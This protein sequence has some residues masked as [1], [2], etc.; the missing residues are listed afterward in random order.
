M[1]EGLVQ[2]PRSKR[3]D[4]AKKLVRMWPNLT[5]TQ[6]LLISDSLGQSFVDD[7]EDGLACN[8]IVLIEC[9]T[10][11]LDMLEGVLASFEK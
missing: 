4:L 2:P 10:D 11:V 3:G 9:S 6:Q 5:A 8:L 1:E 7:E